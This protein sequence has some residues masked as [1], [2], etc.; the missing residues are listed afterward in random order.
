[1]DFTYDEYPIRVNA[2]G[3][4]VKIPRYQFQGNPGKYVHIQANIHGPEV[5]GIAA[6]YDLIKRLQAEPAINGT[7]TVIPSINPVGLD[8]KYNGLQVGYA[9]PDETSVGN[10]NRIY[11]ML[12]KNKPGS[13]AISDPEDPQ[14][15]ILEDFV[16]AHLHS[17]VE[18]ILKEFKQSLLTALA[19]LKQK[20]SRLG[21]RYGLHLAIA[22][23]EMA[24]QA[25][26]LIDLHT[27]GKAIYYGYSFMECSESFKSFDIPYMIEVD[28]DDFDGVLD[29]AFLIPWIRLVKAFKEAGRE[30]TLKEL[31]LEA[32]TL[33]LGNADEVDTLA[34]SRDADRILNYLRYKKVL[35]GSDLV[36]RPVS[37]CKFKHRDNYF[38][39]TGGL[40]FWHRQ[41][42]EK[43]EKGDVVA[44]ILQ[45]G[46]KGRKKLPLETPV[47]AT[48]SGILL[49]LSRSQVA[50]EGIQIFSILTNLTEEE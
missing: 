2:S 31:D 42:G 39:P 27:D 13:S 1:M 41:P 45:P 33:E 50:H 25:D 26:Y 11:Q 22:I 28:P 20:R 23:Q 7:I 38:A 44:T 30:I 46:G 14:K 19:D 43:I 24:H 48:K 4:I 35:P 37:H 6:C 47:R 34:A 29:E 18:L 17:P 36:M 9:D 32:H 5:A 8:L 21:L 40:V 12:V 16:A 49:N 10:F 15:V 3:N